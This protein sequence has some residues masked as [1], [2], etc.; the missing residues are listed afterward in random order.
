MVF[1]LTGHQQE[2]S[3]I[4]VSFQPGLTQILGLV[5][6][7]WA[8]RSLWKRRRRNDS[9]RKT[10]DHPPGT[11]HKGL[12]YLSAG[13]ACLKRS[14]H[15][16]WSHV[17]GQ[18]AFNAHLSTSVET[19][20]RLRLDSCP[21]RTSNLWAPFWFRCSTLTFLMLLCQ[22]NLVE[23]GPEPLLIIPRLP[24]SVTSVGLELTCDAEG[25]LSPPRGR[26]AAP[27]PRAGLW[28]RSLTGPSDP[29]EWKHGFL[30]TLYS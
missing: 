16:Q 18:W 10:E 1:H 12:E 27:G 24:L 5:L 26:S 21:R 6:P 7:Y 17:M 23:I 4:A 9:V 19:R 25:Q 13:P 29:R 28:K 22:L 14:R 8:S 15:V 2:S 20:R 3:S 11:G 30:E